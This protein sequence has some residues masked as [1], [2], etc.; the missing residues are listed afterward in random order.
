M[1]KGWLDFRSGVRREKDYWE[2]NRRV[3]SGGLPHR[4]KV[5]ARLQE[6]LGRKEDITYVFLYYIA[7]KDLLIREPELTFEQGPNQV[8]REIRV[9]KLDS[10]MREGIRQ[11]M[12]EDMAGKFNEENHNDAE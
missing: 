8:C 11:V 9:M 6:I 1:G 10:R 3:F 5:R 7:L 2:F 4:G 12:E